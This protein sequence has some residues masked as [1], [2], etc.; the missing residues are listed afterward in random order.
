MLDL[1]AT[2]GL[3]WVVVATFTAGL[4]YGF[5]GFGAALVY[6]PVATAVIAPPLAIGAFAV[7]ALAS[8]V[9]LV[10]R[11]WGQADRPNVLMMVGAAILGAPLGIWIL[12]TVDTVL[13]RWGLSAIITITLALLIAGWRY[14]ASPTKPVRATIGAAA[15]VMMGSVGLNGP[16]VI[17]FQLGGQDSIARSRA[18]TLIFLTL[19]SL[20]L[21]PLMAWQG[22]IGWEAVWLGLL[23]LLPY[24]LGTLLGRTLFDPDRE[25]LYR[26]VAYAVVAAAVLIGLPVWNH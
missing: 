17:L 14:R 6:M 26:R 22:L 21:V 11:A 7:S 12:A 18:N 23:L 5:S 8:L 9:T 10:P 19:S 13:I 1:L 3:I 15:G 20:S 4:V 2:P 16:L 24:G 25:R